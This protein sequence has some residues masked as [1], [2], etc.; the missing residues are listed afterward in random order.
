MKGYFKR[1]AQVNNTM[2][3]VN[4]V[5]L[6]ADFAHHCIFLSMNTHMTVTAAT[7][8]AVQSLT[9]GQT[10]TDRGCARKRNQQ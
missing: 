2:K 7:R 5:G 6:L 4:E 10:R 1:E 8:N 9:T 3:R